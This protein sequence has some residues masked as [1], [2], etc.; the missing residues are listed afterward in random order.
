MKANATIT[1]GLAALALCG[2]AM[3]QQAKHPDTGAMEMPAAPVLPAICPTGK[4]HLSSMT[5]MKDVN[6]DQRTLMHATIVLQGSMMLGMTAAEPDIAF[7]CAMIPHHQSAIEMAKVELQDGKAGPMRDMAQA[8]I[9]AQE[10]EIA[11]LTQWL[12]QQSR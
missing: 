1:A 2:P 3:A 10:R 5:S 6:E 7:A 8:I 9:D 4:P 12:E 11:E